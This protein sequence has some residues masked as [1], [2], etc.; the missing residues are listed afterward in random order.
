MRAVFLTLCSLLLAAPQSLIVPLPAQSTQAT[1]AALGS[2]SGQVVQNPVGMPVRKIEVSLVA[3]NEA[4][5]FSSRGRQ[6]SPFSA[7][8]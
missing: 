2:V 4:V 7:L 1:V 5:V 8:Y 3:A 6:G